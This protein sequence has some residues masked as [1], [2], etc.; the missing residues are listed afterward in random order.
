LALAYVMRRYKD[1][2]PA[3]AESLGER[4][5]EVLPSEGYHV[6]AKGPIL[7]VKWGRANSSMGIVGLYLVERGTPEEKLTRVFEEAG[8]SFQNVIASAH[9]DRWPGC[10]F[11]PHTRVTHEAIDLWWGAPAID[12]APVR[13]RPIPRSLLGV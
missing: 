3:I 10:G 4:L 2:L 11:E 6:E 9:R 12:D 8:E 5:R 1:A 7:D 13:L